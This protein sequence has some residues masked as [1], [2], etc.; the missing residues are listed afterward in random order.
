M[1]NG[2]EIKKQNYTYNWLH[3]LYVLF[4][5]RYEKV[6][7][8]SHRRATPLNIQWSGDTTVLK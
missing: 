5:L 3:M 6:Y 4:L 7:L 1:T 2:H 8:M